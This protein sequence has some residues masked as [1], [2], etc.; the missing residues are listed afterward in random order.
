MP[1]TAAVVEK[2]AQGDR[3]FAAG[4][5]RGA[6]FAY[7]DAVF[8]QPG[9]AFARVK[10]GRAYLALRYPAQA[11][12]QAELALSAD[13]GSEDARR[14]SEDAR[15]QSAAPAAAPASAPAV[16]PPAAAS[17]APAVAAA[18]LTASGIPPGATVVVVMPAGA[19]AT[20]AVPM[21]PAA[22]ASPAATPSPQAR[23]YRLSPGALDAPAPVPGPTAPTAAPS[24]AQRY[25]TALNLVSR[26]DFA[27]AIT[28]LNEAIAL[29]PRLAVAYTARASARFGLGRFSDAADDYKAAIGLD[30]ALATPLYGLA[31]CYRLLGDPLAAE[32]YRRYAA[33]RAPDVREDLR[34]I[35]HARAEDLTRR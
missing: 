10:L 13:P 29:D 30:P 1:P 12:A 16:A 35:A 15:A 27:G 22:P 5:L 24:A 4:D 20:T 3:A 34:A 31:E 21:P 2:L 33:S 14:L 11:I 17:V 8:L 23:T 19:P 25:R 32:L 7:Q 9:Y 18:G 28:L 6:L 26:R